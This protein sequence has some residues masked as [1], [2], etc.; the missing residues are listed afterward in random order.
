[1][2][3]ACS[4]LHFWFT[5]GVSTQAEN[6]DASHSQIYTSSRFKRFLMG[7]ALFLRITP[8]KVDKKIRNAGG[9]RSSHRLLHLPYR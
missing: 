1:M 5:L 2:L 3:F 7:K 4:G 9:E 8:F 6:L